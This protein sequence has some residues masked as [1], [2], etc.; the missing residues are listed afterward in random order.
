ME[1]TFSEF[2]DRVCRQYAPRPA[3]QEFPDHP[4]KTLTYAQLAQK[5][6]DRVE[7]LKGRRTIIVRGTS[8]ADWIIT[9]FASAAGGHQTVLEGIND[10]EIPATA[11]E[12]VPEYHPGCLLFFTSG[13]T[14]TGK[15]VVLSQAALLRSAWNGQQ[16]LP[17]T[18][19]DRILSMLP[20]SHVF[21]FVCTLLWPLSQGAC[22]QVGSGMRG[23]TTD[24]K[25]FRPTILPVV[26]SLL[27]YL[28][29]TNAL[30]PELRVILVGAGPCRRE[31]L[32]SVNRMGIDIYFGY[33]LTETASGLAISQ[34]GRDPFAMALCPDTSVRIA[35]DGELLVR[36]PCMMEGYFNDPEETAVRL[37]DG[38]LHTGDLAEFRDGALYL[39]GR[40]S[41]VLVLENGEKV[42]CPEAEAALMTRLGRDVALTLRNGVLTLVVNAPQSDYAAIA[43]KI[44]EYNKDMPLGRKILGLELRRQSLPRTLTGKIQRWKL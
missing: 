11:L 17:C 40:K 44:T 38:E 2:L 19:D 13:T 36:T 27:A 18:C 4:E 43:A 33:G 28:L 6:R 10:P 3:I 26:P 25:A 32:E 21:G 37:Q 15:A 31:V 24:P 30:N 35:D 23:Y 7:E 22:V 42:Y 5:I 14:G 39:K 29:K 16:M 12:A 1:R 8:S 41:D 9:M 34:P 20:L